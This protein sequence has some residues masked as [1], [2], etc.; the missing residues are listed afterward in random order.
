[1][2]CTPLG[3]ICPEQFAIPSYWDEDEEDQAKDK[4]KY[5][6]QKQSQTYPSFSSVMTLTLKP[7]KLIITKYFNSMSSET[8]IMYTPK[9]KCRCFTILAQQEL[10]TTEC[11]VLD[12]DS[13]EDID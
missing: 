10:N 12:Q 13:L 1:M 5:N 2:T 3:K 9:E 11:K 7:P 6:D 4:D 8:P